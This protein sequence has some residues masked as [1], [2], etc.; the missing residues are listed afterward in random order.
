MSLAIHY[1]LIFTLLLTALPAIVWAAYVHAEALPTISLG[2]DF[3]NGMKTSEVIQFSAQELE[4][5]LETF[6]GPVPCQLAE[7]SSFNT[8]RLKKNVNS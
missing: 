6:K 1:S 2:M 3:L 7:T 4:H 5:E 8:K